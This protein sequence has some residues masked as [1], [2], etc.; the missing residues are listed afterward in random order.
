MIIRKDNLIPIHFDGLKI[1]DYTSERQTSS[2]FAVIEVPAQARHQLAKS[3]QSDKYY[4]VLQGVVCFHVEESEYELKKGD[5]CLVG[6]GKPFSYR[7]VTSEPACLVLVHTP[8]FDPG[9]EVFLQV[10]EMKN[11]ERSSK[12]KSKG[13]PSNFKRCSH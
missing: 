8:P 13:R 10:E 1:Y 2:S 6:Q 12:M 7:N 4:Y 5:F 9:A 3:N 11:K